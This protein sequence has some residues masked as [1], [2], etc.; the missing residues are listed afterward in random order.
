MRGS[1]DLK[2]MVTWATQKEAVSS[3][4]TRGLGSECS[5]EC[6]GWENSSVPT[7]NGI[8]SCCVQSAAFGSELGTRSRSHRTLGTLELVPK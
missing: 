3:S 6:K 5:K 1:D 4:A 7:S 2:D 8:K